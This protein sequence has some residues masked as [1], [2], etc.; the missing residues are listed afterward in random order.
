MS[1][2]PDEQKKNWVEWSG[3]ALILVQLLIPLS[4][5]VIIHLSKPKSNMGLI[6]TLFSGSF[7]YFIS[8]FTVALIMEFPKNI[9]SIWCCEKT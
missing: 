8:I 3:T 6:K 5:L 7:Y 2:H 9:S 1:L 4:C